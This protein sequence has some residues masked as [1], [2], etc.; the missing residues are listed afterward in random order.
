MG[1][2]IKSG[3][4]GGISEPIT[5]AAQ[6]RA[7]GSHVIRHLDRFYMNNRNTVGE[8]IFVR[9]TRTF[10]APE[11]DDPLPGSIRLVDAS[12]NWAQY[13]QAQVRAV[14]AQ[15]GGAQPA[16]RPSIPAPRPSTPSPRPPG[17][18]IRPDIP[19]WKRP[20][21]VSPTAGYSFWQRLGRFGRKGA[22]F[23]VLTMDMRSSPTIPFPS[24]DA[25]DFEKKLHD[26][27]TDLLDPWDATHN[28][29]V[30]D[31]YHEELQHH[32][33]RKQAPAEDPAA[34]P[35]PVPFP[36]NVR[37][38]EDAERPRCK[39]QLICFMPVSPDVDRTEFRRQLK[40]QER[41]LNAM[42]PGEMLGNRGAYLANPEGMRKLSEPLQA[43]TR[44][45]YYNA[46]LPEFV[47]TYGGHARAELDAHMKTVAA[48]HN[49]DMIAGG[50]YTSVA[51]P[52]I[53]LRDRIGG[54]NE[55]SS[56]GSQWRGG[57]SQRL[58]NHAMEQQRNGCPSVQVV[59]EICVDRG[60]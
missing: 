18:V 34:R 13:A 42:T 43:E 19:Q 24:R 17:Q 5:H 60:R 38:D 30:R 44:A 15:Q 52:S 6:V 23:S 29:R 45:E 22:I 2:G 48:L 8:A 9:D 50:L 53:P 20:P 3:T 4:V 47:R 46:K 1:K 14:P 39:V 31:W 37:V 21:P 35:Q 36:D 10:A 33:E 27:A 57:R 25:D 16:T 49:P 55:N 54:L 56:M 11:D 7:E 59:L 12:G 51:D 26:T 40:L 32:R 41:A 58:A 28:N